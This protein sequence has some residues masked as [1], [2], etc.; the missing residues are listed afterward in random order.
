[1]RNDVIFTTICVG[2]PS[3]EEDRFQSKG[4]NHYYQVANILI[5]SVLKYSTSKIIVVTDMPDSFIKHERVIIYDIQELATEPLI[6]HGYFNYHLKRFALQK[7]F[8]QPETY[9]IYLDC[10]VFLSGKMPE[11]VFDFMDTQDYDV[12]GRL[13][14]ET[15]IQEML[16]HHIPEAFGKIKEF[17]VAWEDIY[18]GAVLPHETFLLFKK[19]EEKQ[20][21]FLETWDNIAK[22]SIKSDRRI[23]A[24]SYY[25]GASIL[26]A[27]MN[28][29]C[30]TINGNDAT[31]EFLHNLNIIH[32]DE[33]NTVYVTPIEPFDYH[34]LLDR[35]K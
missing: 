26:K 12:G 20:R 29:L 35:M 17:G 16:D 3:L 21:I 6:I 8:K 2:H 25:I 14:G 19:N 15:T 9:A 11:D 22:N 18:Y 23:Y 24:D 34:A 4:E 30:F 31:S 27:N 28:R 1:M 5:H 10:D 32:K 13:G 7:A 33:V